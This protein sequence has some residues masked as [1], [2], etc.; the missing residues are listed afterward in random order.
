MGNR[1]M[2]SRALSAGL[3]RVLDDG[4]QAML[5]LN[6]RGS[7]SFV[8]CRD[9]GYVAVCPRCAVPLTYHGEGESLLCH[10]CNRR[11]P[12]PATCPECSGKRIRYFG[13]GT[14]RVEEAVHLEFPAARDAPVGP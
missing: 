10:H 4:Q 6:R 3:Q 14:E 2:F 9:C 7:A 13:A 5:Y 8:M 12:V 1:S 11:Y